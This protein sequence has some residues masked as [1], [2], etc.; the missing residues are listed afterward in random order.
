MPFPAFS[1]LPDLLHHSRLWF[2][3]LVA[4]SKQNGFRAIII[5]QCILTVILN[6]VAFLLVSNLFEPENFYLVWL[7]FLKMTF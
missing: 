1:T 5:V 6:F 4:L 7:V 3:P 2:F